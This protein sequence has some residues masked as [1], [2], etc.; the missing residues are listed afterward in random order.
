M[1]MYFVESVGKEQNPRSYGRPPTLRAT[2]QQGMSPN[3]IHIPD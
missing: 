1:C 2:R 3:M